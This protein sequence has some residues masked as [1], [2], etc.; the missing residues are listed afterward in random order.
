MTEPF[1]RDLGSYRVEREIGRGGMGVVLL[2]RDTR[3]DRLV[4]LKTIPAEM[5]RDPERLARFEREAKIVASLNHPNIVTIHSLEE[6]GG[7]RFVTMEYVEGASLAARVEPRGIALAEALDLVIPITD[8]LS[9]AHAKGVVHRDLKPANVIVTTTGSVKVLDFGLAKVLEA[10][11]EGAEDAAS[12]LT[13]TGMVVGTVPYM[14]PEQLRGEE[15]DPRTDLFTVGT[16]LYELLLGRRPFAGTTIAEVASAILRDEPT[17]PSA[18]RSDLPPELDG[19][20]A[21]CLAKDPAQRFPTAMALGEA[22]ASWRDSTMGT[23]SLAAGAVTARVSAPEAIAPSVAVLPFANLSGNPDDAYFAD[24]LSEEL[25]SVLSRVKGLRVAA[26]TSS[27]HFKDKT[28]DVDA[29]A[30]RLRV[31]TVLEGSVRT[32]GRRVRINARLVHGSDGYPLWSETYDRE[33]GDIF[34]IQDA[35]A[36]SVVHELRR[37]LL[38]EGPGIPARDA[39]VREVRD[40]GRGRGEDPEAYQEYLHGRYFAERFTKEDLAKA[41]G[42]YRRAIERRPDYAAAWAGLARAHATEAAYGWAGVDEGFAHARE[43]A[44][45]AIA[46]DEHLA[47]AHAVLGRIRHVYE[48]DAAGAEAAYRRALELAP[49]D[50]VVVR[51]VAALTRNAGRLEEAAA[52]LRPAVS[53]DPLN[54][55]AHFGLAMCCFW[56]DALDEA[57]AEFQKALELNPTGAATPFYL[58]AVHAAQGRLKDAAAMIEREPVEIFRLLGRVVLAHAAGDAAEGAAALGELRERHADDAAYQIAMGHAIRG[59]RDEA[60]AWLERAE[61]Q[62]DAGLAEAKPDVF[63]RSLRD[64]PRWEAFLARR[65]RRG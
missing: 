34:A 14:A 10:E 24:G 44:M 11:R 6:A 17:P 33:M 16:L 22:L 18:V 15:A 19:L 60:F 36:E 21:R 12:S 58:A 9:A 64:D 20:V 28:G 32:A 26:R 57:E 3:L 46:L 49:H 2:A 61:A 39:L 62:R 31:A 42:Y 30:R 13:K 40:A 7:I 50:T 4:A 5:A 63:L 23:R 52:L 55:A 38:G 1:P 41:I 8:A 35:I 25:L 51:A 37:A 65:G 59:E 47:E 45:R 29:I 53:R 56:S 48:H 54:E 43:A 27:F